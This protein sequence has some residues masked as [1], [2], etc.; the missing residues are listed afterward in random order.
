MSDAAAVGENIQ[1]TDTSTSPEA[2]ANILYAGNQPPAQGTTEANSQANQTQPT[3]ELHPNAN[4]QDPQPGQ[5]QGQ[6]NQTQNQGAP[7]SYSFKPP[8]GT[9]LDPVAIG[10]FSETAK[11]LGLSQEAAQKVVDKMLPILAKQQLEANAAL[12]AKYRAAFRAD[13]E[14]GGSEENQGKTLA[15]A[16]K[17]ID[18]FG[19]PELRAALAANP[20]GSNPELIRAFYKIGQKISADTVVTGNA[21]VKSFQ[22]A[23]DRLYSSQ[24]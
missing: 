6:E 23:A 1:T 21:P 3:T 14:L 24:H 15:L 11:E 19:T 7:E 2:A 4:P 16:K 13:K 20:L 12:D 17:V 9:E 18:Q 5:Q 22:D 10:A 8:E